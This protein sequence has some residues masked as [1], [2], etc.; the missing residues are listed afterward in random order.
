M[1]GNAAE[2]DEIAACPELRRPISFIPIMLLRPQLLPV[3]FSLAFVAQGLCQSPETA[4]GTVYHDQNENQVRDEG[5]PGIPGVLVSN[6]IEVVKTDADG[7]W[8]LPVREDCIFFVNKPRNWMTPLDSKMLPRFYYIH[9]PKGSP[10]DFKYA[11]VAPTGDLPERIDFPLY[12][13]E[14][15]DK[16]QALFFGDTQARNQKELDYMAHDVIEE[17]IGHEARFGVTLGDIL[18]DDLSIYDNHNAL[19]ALIGVP[20]YNVIG[21]HDLNFDS[22][23]DTLSDETFERVF[24]PPYYAYSYGP[25]HFIALDNVTW[26]GRGNGYIGKLGSQQLQ[27]IENLLPHIP[28]E[29]LIL[30]MMHIPVTGQQ[31]N[32]ELFRL[33]EDRPYTMSISGHTHWQAHHFLD[34]E[35]G[36]EGEKPH[37]HVIN[38]TVCGSWWSGEPDENGIPHTTMRDG[39]PNGYSIITFDGQSATV[40]FKAARRPADYQMNIHTPEVVTSTDA[41][42]QWIYVNVFGGSERSKVEFRVGAKGPWQTLEKTVEQDPYFAMLKEREA[43]TPEEHLKGR[44]LPKI[45]LSDH[46]WKAPLPEGLKPGVHRIYVKTEDQYGRVFEASRVM[47]VE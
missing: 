19:V 39:A 41:P 28:E 33:I 5:E 29:D 15:P 3:C 20:W 8:S 43:S 1:P 27:F 31:D 38:V 9:K 25:V 10:S 45:I 22:P 24:G 44:P 35:D 12:P 47:R 23:D 4:H 34:K 13:Q 21:N 7:N 17:L 16:F 40:D 46:L 26:Q 30:L 6:Q 32:Q 2:P 37:H 42:S 14:E 36:W 18:F 11:G